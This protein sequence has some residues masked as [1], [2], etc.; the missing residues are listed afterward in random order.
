M[1]TTTET[2]Q[3]FRTLWLNDLEF[4]AHAMRNGGL[5]AASQGMQ[6]HHIWGGK[7][8]LNRKTN[9]IRL[10]ATVH[11]WMHMRPVEGR[12]ACCW[13][14]KELGVLDWD[15]L[16]ECAGRPARAWVEV[17]QA[18]GIYAAMQRELLNE[19]STTQRK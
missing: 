5:R 9:L 19:V 8:R 13:K 4:R 10:C 7:T 18:S 1:Q 3:L 15:V 16:T 12:I 17:Q 6:S 14:Q 2:C 11:D